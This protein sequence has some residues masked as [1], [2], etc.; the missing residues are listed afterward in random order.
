MGH[1][2][3]HEAQ[4]AR[5]SRRRSAIAPTHL[6]LLGGDDQQIEVALGWREPALQ[7]GHV[8]R[9]RDRE[10]RAAHLAGSRRASATCSLTQIRIALFSSRPWRMLS[11]QA[12]RRLCM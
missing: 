8:D 12:C 3:V 5:G 4:R 6:G 7:V 1:L 10:H 9:G 11:G 2:V